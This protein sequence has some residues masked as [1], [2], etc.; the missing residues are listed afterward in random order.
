VTRGQLPQRAGSPGLNGGG[1][2][3]PPRYPQD[4]YSTDDLFNELV[5]SFHPVVAP[6]IIYTTTWKIQRREL[7][8]QVY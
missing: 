6:V 1:A 3:L 4:L 2:A 7:G 8:Q 5:Y